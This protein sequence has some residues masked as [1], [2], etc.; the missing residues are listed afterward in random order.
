VNSD[1]KMKTVWN[2]ME[3]E[4]GKMVKNEDTYQLNIDGNT[5]YDC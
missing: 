5:T 3:S 4:I 1:N 2:S